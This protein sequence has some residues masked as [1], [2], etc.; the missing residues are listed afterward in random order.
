MTATATPITNVA[1]T[2]GR[3]SWHELMTTDPVAAQAF[4]K[5]VIGW[6]TTKYE[7]GTMDYTM[8]VA[9]ETPIGGVMTLP[10]KAA[11]MG[12]PPHW[13]AYTDVV[14]ADATINQA[15][16]LGANV[17]VPAQTVENVGRFAILS[18]PQGAVFAII[19]NATPL[20]PE[21]DPAALEFCWHELTTS[22]VT[23]AIKFYE[24]VF[25]W[26]QLQQFDM[27]EGKGTYHIFGRGQFRYGG[28]MNKPEGYDAPPNW[29][30]YIEVDSADAATERATK[31]GGKV[32]LGPM[33]VPGG[34]RI[35]IMTDPQ[36]AAFA[37]H[38]NAK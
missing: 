3:F 9:G 7:A 34:A 25:G 26:Q 10:T 14:D 11:E 29:L 16:S 21:R 2:G 31:A 1:V 32:M 36:G 37:V 22:D 19:A 20:P 33:E 18:D 5:E 38:S 30:H 12:A 24:T 27:G 17:L 23:A 4:Y 35:S 28:M 13:L 6:G 8:W 15:V